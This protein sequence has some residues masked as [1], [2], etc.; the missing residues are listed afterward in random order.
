MTTFSSLDLI[1]PIQRALA[2]A[3]YTEPTPIQAAAIPPLLEGRDVLGC[4]QTLSLIH[5]SE[6][7]R[8]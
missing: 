5:I 1:E 3:R 8:P 4:A 2:D 6:P 7:T